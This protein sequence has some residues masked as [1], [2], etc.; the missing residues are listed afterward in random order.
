MS[1]INNIHGNNNKSIAGDNN[2][3]N[4]ETKVC[5]LVTPIGDKGTKKR[6]EA[7]NLFE[8]LKLIL[9]DYGFDVKCSHK[10]YKP[11]SITPEIIDF[12]E[13]S[14]LIIT[15]LTGLNPNVMYEFGYRKGIKRPCIPIAKKRTNLPFDIQ[16][17]RTIFYKEKTMPIDL[18]EEI[19]QAI[20]AIFPPEPPTTKNEPD[21]QR[22]SIN[23]LFIKDQSNNTKKSVK[24]LFK[25]HIQ[26]KD[27]GAP[28]Q[29]SPLSI[30]EYTKE[31]EALQGTSDA[32][33]IYIALKKR[34]GMT[35]PRN[36]MKGYTSLGIINDLRRIEFYHQTKPDECVE[37]ISKKYLKNYTIS[38]AFVKCLSRL[39]DE[40]TTFMTLFKLNPLWKQAQNYKEF[41]ATIEQS[42]KE[43][44]L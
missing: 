5:F 14:E 18:Q 37:Y 24:Q 42:R 28:Q 26:S 41:D 27:D 10:Q 36:S 4:D 34:P 16:D 35:Y 43:L 12:L 30:R 21:N 31:S 40:K 17:I 38:Y 25:T 2:T 29:K 33:A 32:K 19:P 3:M 6:Q 13:K 23:Q 22:K 7:D 9:K 11:T 15:N 44:N 39:I 20:Q 8:I 1:N